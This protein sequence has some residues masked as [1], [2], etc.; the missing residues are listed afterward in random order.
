MSEGKRALY[1]IALP[2]GIYILGGYN[3]KEYLNT[4][5]RFDPVTKKWTT[6]KPMN[7][8]RGTFAAVVSPNFNYIYV[9]GGFNGQPLNHVER[10]D[11]MNN[12]WDYLASMKQ[13]RFMHT[14]S[15]INM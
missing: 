7:T 6:L 15:L 3:G 8:S 9:I 2:D 4:V 5:E 10:F 11:V 12:T 1:A 13:K 14:A